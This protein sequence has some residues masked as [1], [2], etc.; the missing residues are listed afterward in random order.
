M[1]ARSPPTFT[2]WYCGADRGLASGDHLRRRQRIDEAHQAALLQR[3]EGDDRH[4]ALPRILQLVQHARAV[5]ADVLA[6]EQDAVGVLEVL[7]HHR[8][9]RAR[10]WIFGSPTE[11]LSWHMLELSGRLLQP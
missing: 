2:W 7:Q 11:V 9:H 10:R 5:G 8:A 6:E 1:A 4:A 3:I